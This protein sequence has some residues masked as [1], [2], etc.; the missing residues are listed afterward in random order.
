[1]V[2]KIVRK[3]GVVEFGFQRAGGEDR[4]DLG[5]EVQRTVVRVM[6]VERLNTEPVA[7]D[8]Q[9]LFALV[10]NRKRKHA[11]QVLNAINAV[12]FVKMKNGFSVAV[13]LVNVAAGFE[14]LAKA[15]VVV[16]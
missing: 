12:F 4:F 13:G 16:D 8:E 1:M 9:L 2:G 10:P 6:V 5:T 15:G 14:R 11:A 7:S 3:R